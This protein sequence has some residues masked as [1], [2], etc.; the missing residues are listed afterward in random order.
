MI[1]NNKLLKYIVTKKIFLQTITK[2]LINEN[3]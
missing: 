1:N 2:I 3:K